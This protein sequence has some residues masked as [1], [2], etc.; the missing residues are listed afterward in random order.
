M[1]N[2]ILAH[3]LYL[4]YE[5]WVPAGAFVLGFLFDIIMLTRIDDLFSLIQ[6]TL[7]ILIIGAL[8]GVE[9]ISQV[10]ELKP[11]KLLAKIWPYREF[12]LHF[13]LGS[14]LNVYVLFYFKSSS[15]FISFLFILFL[16]AIL[17]I[18]EFKRFGES[19]VQVHMGLLSLCV[20]SYLQALIPILFGFVGVFPFLFALG[21]A[22]GAFVAF[23][24]FLESKLKDKPSLLFTHL[25]APFGAVIAGFF[26][27]YMTHILP[28]IPL[29]VSYM[30]IFH[31]VEK[32]N[33]KFI[34]SYTRPWWRFW[35]HGDETFYARPGDTLIGYAQVFSPGRFRDKLQI[36]WT[37]KNAHGY[38]EP[39]D[40]IP[41]EVTGGRDEGFRI[42]VV[43]KNYHPGQWR[44]QIETT[45]NREVGWLGFEI[46]EDQA[47]SPRTMKHVV[48]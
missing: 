12:A 1:R 4:K 13:L 6:Q 46:Y 41:L 26:I 37:S 31:E 47:T 30:G 16:A 36:R 15:G 23:Y 43:K 39:Q 2:V 14:L 44:V 35:E 10:R 29:S 40:A 3:P 32:K 42:A 45:D 17:T 28:P 8:I 48:R 27:L 38:W 11:P 21:L 25:T 34:L 33:G 5:R 9:L 7:Y 22:L 24:R 20:I 18:T 19:Q